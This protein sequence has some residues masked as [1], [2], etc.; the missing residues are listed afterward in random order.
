MEVEHLHAENARLRREVSDT[1]RDKVAHWMAS[2][3][4]CVWSEIE[5][6]S[7]VSVSPL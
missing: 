6:L 1:S 4:S 7:Y 5:L 3:D 2:C